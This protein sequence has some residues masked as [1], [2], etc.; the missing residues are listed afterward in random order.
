MQSAQRGKTEEEA[1][2]ELNILTRRY[3]LAYLS[4]GYVE[5]PVQKVFPGMRPSHHIYKDAKSR[6]QRM[7]KQWKTDI[8]AAAHKWQVRYIATLRP[9]ISD[10]VANIAT[11]K[12]FKAEVSQDYTKAWL[13]S[14]FKFG[15][16]AV[17]FD[18]I[19]PEGLRFLKCEYLQKPSAYIQ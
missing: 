15:I 12:E 8:L 14:V 4:N 11:F 9:T 17:D 19:Q 6:V 2:T 13:D 3:F 16:E 7:Y 18:E 10:H 5:E 1:Y